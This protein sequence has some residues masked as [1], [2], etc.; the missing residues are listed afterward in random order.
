MLSLEKELYKIAKVRLRNDDD[1]YDA[2]QETTIKAFKFVKKLKQNQYFKT[3]IIKILINESNNIY[4]RK[5]KRRIISF[6]ELE[7]NREIEYYNIDNVEITLD[8]NFICNKLKYED[9]IIIILYYMEKF[10]DK[11]IGKILNLK[12]NTIKT[13]RA[14][15]KQKIKKILGLGGKYNGWIR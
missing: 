7:N 9:R 15:A 10:T 14:R 11:E 2:I 13:K 3:W 1:I 5:N 4:R 8:F 6:E 12:E